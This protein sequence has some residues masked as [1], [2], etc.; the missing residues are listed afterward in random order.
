MK[1]PPNYCKHFKNN[2]KNKAFKP[3]DDEFAY[4][5][6]VE[7]TRMNTDPFV[8]KA[9][10]AWSPSAPISLSG[11]TRRAALKV[12]LKSL[13]K[14]GGHEA[15]KSDIPAD[16]LPHLQTAINQARQIFIPNEP[17][18]RISLS[19][20]CDTLLGDTPAGFSFPGKLKDEVRDEAYDVASYIQHV[21]KRGGHAYEPPCKIALRG[22]LTPVNSPKSRPVWIYPMEMVI[23]EGKWAKPFYD[24][25][26]ENVPEVLC[27]ADSMERLATLLGSDMGT[28][29]NLA[30]VTLD[31]SDFDTSIPN[32]L[33]DEA[34]KI[35]RNSFDDSFVIHE[36]D[37]IF[38]GE[39]RR[40]KN[41]YVWEYLI[42]YFK[43]TKIMLPDGSTYRKM[44]GIP[45]GSYFAQAIGSI[46][47]YI[48]IRALDY[49]FNLSGRKFRVLG[50][51]SMFLIPG[52]GHVKFDINR[53]CSKAF[54]VFGLELKKDKVQIT[55]SS[56][57][58]KF[59]GYQVHGLR[60]VR[61]SEE[62]MRLVLYP[63]H[64][65][66]SLE[67]SAARV[68]T[69]YLLGGVNDQPYCSFFWYF[70]SSY[71]LTSIDHRC[72]TKE[73]RD[74]LRLDVST[75]EISDIRNL[76]PMEVSTWLSTGTSLTEK[77]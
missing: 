54:E 74:A 35:I 3:V 40:L 46:V 37:I 4:S 53:L 58:R 47:N 50:G 1:P 32:W 38:R 72:L 28:H 39:K 31:W 24:H 17:L 59:L 75:P 41:K 8:R 44:H 70:F 55:T 77:R 52:W 49:Y 25:L 71:Q 76:D 30:S 68:L 36:N 21:V 18:Y 51:D 69:Y 43:K 56:G 63:E 2:I 73:L 65:I 6:N 20:S 22:Y 14:F 61:S 13:V 11:Y 26:E 67:D 45:D 9:L 62:W 16:F 57:D 19:E 5:Y 12:A 34:F 10:K 23:L 27:G 66:E 29:T 64:D 15:K 48:A 33:I 60:F 7:E 42:D